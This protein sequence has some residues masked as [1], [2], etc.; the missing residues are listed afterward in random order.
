MFP[1]NATADAAGQ[2]RTMI[3]RISS[4]LRLGSE[5]YQ[6]SCYFDPLLFN[7][8]T[9]DLLGITLP[10][11]LNRAVQKRKAEFVAGRYCAQTALTELY[12]GATPL[13]IS[14]GGAIPIGT[15]PQRAPLWP[16]G[17]V[18]SI[19]HTQ[20]VH[21]G[22]LPTRGYA[23]AVV[24]RSHQVRAIGI[25][26]ENWIDAS[27]A[28]NIQHQILTPGDN[29]G[30]AQFASPAQRLTVIFSA[31]ESVFKCLYPLV[32]RFFDFQAAA[33]T[34]LPATQATQGSL[35]F[36]LL[37]D[38][39]EEFR[40]GFIGYGCYTIGADGVHTA[41]LLRASDGQTERRAAATA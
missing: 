31:K 12:G 5:C 3:R 2:V 28:D 11:T 27:T 17:I 23:A 16:D 6:A 22:G 25:D 24:A 41:V 40:A 34:L 29:G 36:E 7:N 19:T 32:N 4:P 33:V 10:T 37:Q 8:Q 1:S 30:T 39:N 18:G 9:A 26:S 21:T 35:R 13:L 14:A 38:L 20:S 15:A